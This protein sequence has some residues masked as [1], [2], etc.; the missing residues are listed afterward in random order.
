M[1]RKQSS[2]VESVWRSRLARFRRGDLTVAEFCRREGVSTPSFYQWRKRLELGQQS[3]KRGR[4]SGNG[5]ATAGDGSPF[6]AVSVSPPAIAEVEFP[7]GVRI[8]VPATNVE[9]LRAA[10]LAGSDVWRCPDVK[11]SR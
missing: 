2:K 6:V 9:A 3:S 7:N 1:G 8:R 10:V 5:S 4:R 11:R